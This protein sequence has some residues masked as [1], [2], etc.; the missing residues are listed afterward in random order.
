VDLDLNDFK[1]DN[2]YDKNKIIVFRTHLQ[3]ES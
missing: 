2:N 1:N 3:E